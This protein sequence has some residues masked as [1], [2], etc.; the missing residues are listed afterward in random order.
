MDAIAGGVKATVHYY[1]NRY[2][3]YCKKSHGKI[4]KCKE[5]FTYKKKKYPLYWCQAKKLYFFTATNGC[6]DTDG[7]KIDTSK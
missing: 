4:A 2:C 1:V 7:N 6:F 3:P 5:N